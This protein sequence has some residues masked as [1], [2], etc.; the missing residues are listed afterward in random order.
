MEKDQ[1]TVSKKFVLLRTVVHMPKEERLR[2]PY[3][4]VGVY[5]S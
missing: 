2:T 4:K 1:G 5:R 3:R